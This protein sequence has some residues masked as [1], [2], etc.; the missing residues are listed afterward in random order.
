MTT[1]SVPK[2]TAPKAENPVEEIV[3]EVE[4]IFLPRPGG[5]VDTWH[6]ERA[7]REAAQREAQNAAEK[8]EE[9]ASYAVKVTQLMPEITSINSV[10]I[11]AGATAMVLPNSPYRYRATLIASATVVLAKDNSQALGQVGFSL[12]AN[13]PLVINS[14]A[15]L[16]AFATGAATVSVIAELYA[17]EK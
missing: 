8:I 1:P 14:R 6:K 2:S 9:G 3:E 5:M 17:P 15:Q 10:N 13:T 7:R 4:H 16:Y 12:P 11:A